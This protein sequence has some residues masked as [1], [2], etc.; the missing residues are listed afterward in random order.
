MTYTET[1]FAKTLY[2][3]VLTPSHR[4]LSISR[5][6]TACS[7]CTVWSDAIIS[8]WLVISRSSWT[9]TVSNVTC[10]SSGARA[11]D[12]KKFCTPCGSTCS[13]CSETSSAPTS[14]GGGR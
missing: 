5:F 1:V 10:R 9:E 12:A 7:A 11:R 14:T 4:R 13:A 6:K 8:R 3:H 2:S